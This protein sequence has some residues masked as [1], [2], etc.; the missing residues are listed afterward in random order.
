[1]KIK[2]LK[3]NLGSYGICPDCGGKTIETPVGSECTECSYYFYYG[4][5]AVRV[6]HKNA[7]QSKP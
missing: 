2:F 7:T 1:M 5:S 6:P 3:S 4:G